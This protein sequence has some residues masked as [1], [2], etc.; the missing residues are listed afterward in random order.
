MEE[1]VLRERI[2]P[3]GRAVHEPIGFLDRRLQHGSA[4]QRRCCGNLGRDLGSSARLVDEDAR[5]RRQRGNYVRRQRHL[6]SAKQH[7]PWRRRRWCS[8]LDVADDDGVLPGP[9]DRGRDGRRCGL[10]FNG[11][12]TRPALIPRHQ[13]NVAAR[14]DAGRQ[15][16]LPARRFS[17]RNAGGREIDS[18]QWR[19]ADR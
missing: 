11:D 13:M 14:G 16:H 6:R 12:P 15:L 9:R 7:R 10:G 3:Q 1:Q 19:P 4:R 8:R 18:C 2:E 5:L 17:Q